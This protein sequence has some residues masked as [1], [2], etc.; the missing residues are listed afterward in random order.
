MASRHPSHIYRGAT[1]PRFDLPP[2]EIPKSGTPWFIVL[3]VLFAIV[4][5]VGMLFGFWRAANPPRQAPEHQTAPA[6][7]RPEAP[8]P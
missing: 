3:L 1:E 6:E 8:V 4:T 2:P 7:P 5:V